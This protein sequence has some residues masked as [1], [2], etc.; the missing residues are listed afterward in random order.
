M[1]HALLILQVMIW[2]L[3]SKTDKDTLHPLILHPIIL[4]FLVWNN[5]CYLL[6][7]ETLCGED[8]WM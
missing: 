4:L 5:G 7:A 3:D 2:E 1:G 6:L 8:Q